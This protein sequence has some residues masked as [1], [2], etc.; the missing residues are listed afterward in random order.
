MNSKLLFSLVCSAVLFASGCNTNP[1]FYNETNQPVT[2][3][4]VEQKQT[5]A[6]IL[7]SLI[8]LNKNEIAAAN[9][10]QQKSANHA[11]RNYAESMNKAHSRNLQEAERLSQKLD[12]APKQGQT[13]AQL[14]RKGRQELAALNR[15]QNHAFDRAYINSMVKDHAAAL[16][17]L[18]QRLIPQATN[19]QLRQYLEATRANVAQH[20][21][22]AQAVQNQLA[23]S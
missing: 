22:Q 9:T 1:H 10:A 13:A 18:D 11:V 19:P 21:K 8:V 5:D 4:S 2:H 15:L 23:N 12:V 6:K 14:Q 7:S 17:L 20:L 3:V 16:Q